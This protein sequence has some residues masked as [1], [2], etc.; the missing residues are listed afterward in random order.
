[1]LEYVQYVSVC[2][3][4]CVFVVD[5]RERVHVGVFVIVSLCLFV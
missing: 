2:G 5:E 4:R 1:M 3:S